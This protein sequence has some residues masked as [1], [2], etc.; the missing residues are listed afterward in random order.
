M[1]IRQSSGS[2]RSSGAGLKRMRI[3]ALNGE[4]DHSALLPDARTLQG[5]S[6]KHRGRRDVDF[7]DFQIHA[8]MRRGSIQEADYVRTQKR[9]RDSLP[10]KG[11]GRNH[12]VGARGE[13]VL[14]RGI[15]TGARNDFQLRDS[16]PAP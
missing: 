16:G 7:S 10:G 4:H 2:I 9:L 13:Q 1:A 11:V 3:A 8:E 15:F 14:L 6:R 12:G 5:L